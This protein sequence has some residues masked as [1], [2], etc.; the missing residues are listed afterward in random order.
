MS[1]KKKRS[2]TVK[3]VSNSSSS[4]L[5]TYSLESIVE[6]LRTQCHRD[7]TKKMYYRVRRAFNDFFLR[8]DRKP[9]YWEDCIV[10]FVGYLIEQKKKSTTIKSYLSAIRAVLKQDKY[11]LQEDQFLLKSLTKAC[12]IKNDHLKVRLSIKKGLLGLILH[13]IRKEYEFKM[14]QPYLSLLYHTIIS[15]AYYGLFRIGELTSGDHPVL[16]QDVHIG[17]NK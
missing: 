1:R 2:I 17:T 16:A 9:R 6:K 8:L 3:S 11:N 14:N 7:S 10:L 13:Q 4:R 15:T 5:S 12:C